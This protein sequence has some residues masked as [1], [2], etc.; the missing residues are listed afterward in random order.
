VWR[1]ENLFP[2]QELKPYFLA[3]QPIAY[4]LYHLI[5]NRFCFNTERWRKEG[6][7]KLVGWKSKRDEKGRKL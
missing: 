5:Y 3:V 4:F 2:V 7:G 6:E 1:K